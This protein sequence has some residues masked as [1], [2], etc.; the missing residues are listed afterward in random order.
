MDSFAAALTAQSEDKVNWTPL[1]VQARAEKAVKELMKN[2]CGVAR[3]HVD[4]THGDAAHQA[5]FTWDAIGE[6]RKPINPTLIYNS[7]R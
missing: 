4:W 1:P 6:M 2:G 5:P 7:A 3:T